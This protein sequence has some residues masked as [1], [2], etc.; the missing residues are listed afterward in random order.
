M[1]RSQQ[2]PSIAHPAD[3]PKERHQSR[4]EA[5]PHQPYPQAMGMFEPLVASM[6][7]MDTP[8]EGET[9]WTDEPTSLPKPAPT[10]ALQSRVYHYYQ[11]ST[12]SQ[13]QAEKAKLSRVIY[14]ASERER[15]LVRALAASNG[16]QKSGI[17]TTLKTADISEKDDV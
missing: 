17:E 6:D 14:P 1:E 12:S 3:A 11:R 10:L 7:S 5:I 2:S 9:A 4:A 8:N 16:A 13:L 15:Y